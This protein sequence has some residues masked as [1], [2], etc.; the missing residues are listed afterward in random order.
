MMLA[1]RLFT[2]GHSAADPWSQ[3][4]FGVHLRFFR[5]SVKVSIR[6]TQDLLVKFTAEMDQFLMGRR[7]KFGRES[8]DKSS[9]R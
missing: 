8:A 6:D 2:C 7:V 5:Y 4:S 9:G 3:G 1:T